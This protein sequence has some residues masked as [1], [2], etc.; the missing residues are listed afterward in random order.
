M[1]IFTPPVLPI[2]ANTTV[3]RHPGN[4]LWRHYGGRR[5]GINVYVYADGTIGTNDP[6]FGDITCRKV[7]H[8]GHIHTVTAAEALALT[9]AGFGANIAN[10]NLYNT[11]LYD[12]A[13]Y[14]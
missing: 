12:T 1:P 7:Y 11:A 5:V 2:G 3:A 8:G 9:A 4:Q 14:G 10:S 13:V 6:P